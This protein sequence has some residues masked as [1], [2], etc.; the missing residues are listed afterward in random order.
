M[1]LFI[2]KELFKKACIAFYTSTDSI[3][4]FFSVLIALQTDASDVTRQ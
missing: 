2:E 4:R 1:V 3:I